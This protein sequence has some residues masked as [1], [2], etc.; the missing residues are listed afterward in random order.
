[1]V[2]ANPGG[3]QGTHNSLNTSGGQSTQSSS[4]LQ[5]PNL[6]QSPTII[7]QGYTEQINSWSVI[8]RGSPQTAI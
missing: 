5:S 2:N 4:N 3:G 7:D 1:M 6:T 8:N